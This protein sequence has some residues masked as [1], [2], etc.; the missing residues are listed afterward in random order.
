MNKNEKLAAAPAASGGEDE[1][2]PNCV[3]PWKCNGPHESPA[4]ASVSERAR[5]LLAAECENSGFRDQ[6]EDLRAGLIL[7]GLPG[8]ALRALEQA[9]TQQRGSVWPLN[10]KPEN[11][12]T[13]DPGFLDEIKTRA[14]QSDIGE[15]APCLEGV[16]SVL[17]ALRDIHATTPQPGAEALRELVQRWREAQKRAETDAANA[18]KYADTVAYEYESLAYKE[19]ADE[20]ESLLARGAE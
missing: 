20:L 15:F 9:L 1:M 12:W 16:E 13:F 11:G 10:T 14:E 7:G 6:A 19:C 5:E 2:C 17:I 4:A 18:K 8:V 3:T